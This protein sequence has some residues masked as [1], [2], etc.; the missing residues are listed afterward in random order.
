MF[1]ARAYSVPALRDSLYIYAPGTVR[2]VYV[3]SGGYYLFILG[4]LTSMGEG[5]EG[6]VEITQQRTSTN[7]ET[8]SYRILTFRATMIGPLTTVQRSVAVIP[9]PC[10]P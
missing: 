4:E 5:A 9:R 10:R 7:R 2:P 8:C 6:I 1:D 3:Q